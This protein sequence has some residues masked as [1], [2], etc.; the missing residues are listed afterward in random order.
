MLRVCVIG[1][2]NI[3][4]TIHLP[5][6][7]L[8]PQITLVGIS[9]LS[10]ITLNKIADEFNIKNRYTDYIQM[11]DDLKPDIVSICTPNKYH[12]IQSM[13]ALERGIHVFCEKPPAMNYQELKQMWKKSIEK[14]CTIAFNFH[15]RLRKETLMLKNWVE[16]GRQNDIYYAEINA[17]RRRGIP[18]W[19]NFTNKDLQGG[20]ALIDIGIHMLD[21]FLYVMNYPKPLYVI[22]SSSNRI[23]IKGGEGDFGAW[24]GDKF[25]VEDS[26]YGQITFEGG[27]SVHIKT[28]FAHNFEIKSDMNV[29]LFASD[30]GAKLHPFTR[31]G[32]HDPIIE[33]QEETIQGLSA[34]PNFIE[35]LQSN[36]TLPLT[37]IESVI[38][39]QRLV[40][41]LYLSA[42]TNQPIRMEDH[43]VSI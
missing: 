26:L 30:E 14:K 34:L 1:A 31:Y 5:I 12:Y 24:N 3:A 4:K 25:E 27:L 28:A 7:S 32:N 37:S 6:Y 36:N 43:N 21:L 20:G 8:H 23:G 42:S 39:T 29:S 41:A 19:G 18:G 16:S 15:H 10:E 40:D 22:A 35:S 33:F 11:L 9:D 17:L 13:A 2:G 38:L